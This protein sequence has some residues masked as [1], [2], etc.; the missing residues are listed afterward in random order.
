MAFGNNFLPW[1]TSRFEL[2]RV[3]RIPPE[4]NILHNLQDY[5]MPTIFGVL[6]GA[7][8]LQLF[9]H[10]IALGLFMVV[11][12]MS[13]AFPDDTPQNNQESQPQSPRPR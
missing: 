6:A 1:L 8:L 5:V 13:A 7:F 12:L 3:E 11:G 9:N 10:P 2:E 4:N